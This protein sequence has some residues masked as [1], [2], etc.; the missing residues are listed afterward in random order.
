M[1]CDKLF[2]A[3][4]FG[5][6]KGLDGVVGLDVEHVL[7]SAAFGVFR[8]F[9]YLVDF[10]PVA[11]SLLGE[12]EHVVVHRSGIDVLDEV[13]V[14]GV[15][16]L[17]TD[18]AA[19]LCA[20][21]AELCALDISAV[22]DGDDHVVV[23]I[24]ILGIEV[25]GGVV[26][27]GAACVA[28]LVAYLDELLFDYGATHVVVREYQFESG[29]LLLQLVILV[30]ELVLLQTGELTQTH[31]D[32]GRGLRVGEGET[33]LELFASVHG[34]G[35]AADD[36]YHL[37]DVLRGYDETLE[38]VGALL[39][40]AQLI[41]SAAYHHFVAVGHKLADEFLEVERAGTSVDEGHVVDAER[42]LHLG[43]L[44][45]L[46]EHHVGV[47]VALELDDDAH[48]LVVALVVDVGD[49]V[50]FLVGHEVGYVADE[51]GLVD[52]IG[53]LGY[54]DILVVVLGFDFGL[55]AYEH[56]A[57]ACLI[58]FLDSVVAVDGAA[59]GEVGGGD[60]FHQTGDVDLGV[61]DIGYTG[62][63]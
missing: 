30:F 48:A 38:Y 7:D 14:T 33:L 28:I 60:V 61:V 39:S 51:L 53:Y 1:A 34:V 42:G 9:G 49:A 29:Y 36:A 52:V 22:G 56:S 46:V 62:V 8:A 31:L 50:E 43:H 21:L 55:G 32:D 44:V 63:D 17:C 26:Y 2:V 11:A 4:I 19:V 16:A 59:G 23:G 58:G 15:G 24:E 6:D 20:E 3:E 13:F 47:G 57:A 27:V 10:E 35:R 25:A 54:D 18:A 45:E 40:L 12:E 37:V 5:A 41:F